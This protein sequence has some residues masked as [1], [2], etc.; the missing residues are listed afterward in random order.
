MSACGF[1]NHLR[2][3]LPDRQEQQTKETRMH[4]LAE[5]SLICQADESAPRIERCCANSAR[6]YQK[7]GGRRYVSVSMNVWR[8]ACAYVC[9]EILRLQSA[10]HPCI[11]RLLMMK[12]SQAACFCLAQRGETEHQGR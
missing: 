8:E 12:I 9:A 4:L 11:E 5:K 2:R 6:E 7:N 1:D 3:Q 10:D